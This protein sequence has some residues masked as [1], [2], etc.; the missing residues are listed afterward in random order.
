LTV[1]FNQ[2]ISL[3]KETHQFLDNLKHKHKI[4]KSKIVREL[5]RSYQDKEEK[6]LKIIHES[7]WGGEASNE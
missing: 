5:L 4:A 2:S 1:V 7:G 3:D 6:L